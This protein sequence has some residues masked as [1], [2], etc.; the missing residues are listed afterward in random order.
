MD[1]ISRVAD[2]IDDI[3]MKVYDEADNQNKKINYLESL[4][5]TM[6]YLTGIDNEFIT[7]KCKKAFNEI[8]NINL[9]SEELRQALFLQEI[10][11]Y[12]QINLN[13]DSITPPSIAMI[14][15]YIMKQVDNMTILDLGLGIANLSIIVSHYLNVHTNF[16]GIEQNGILCDLVK[17]KANL[18]QIPM[19]IHMNDCLDFS[20]NNVD[21]IISDV[22]NYEYNNEYYHSPLYD[23]GVR[24]YA[25]LL[26]EKHIH[27]GKDNALSYYIV[28]NDF[29]SYEGN[30]LFK[31]ELFKYAHIKCLIT[32]PSNFF[33][34]KPKIILVISKN[35]ANE[36]VD[37][38]LFNLPSINN[39]TNY[40]KVLNNIKDLLSKE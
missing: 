2:L 27:S 25:Y 1:N 19:E 23:E 13:L 38:T 30:Q 9:N 29:F 4:C 40:L 11:A 18:L 34:G 6:D 21:A 10:K 28:D 39:N 7:N 32:L 37:T 24:S 33:R 20:Y 3:A 14:L 35:N 17:S 22:E 5:I 26:I 36:K 12:K 15:A 8:K 31:N 16:I